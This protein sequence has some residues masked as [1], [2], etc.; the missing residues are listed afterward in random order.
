VL[1]TA[2]LSIREELTPGDKIY[3]IGGAEFVISQPGRSTEDA[4]L[5]KELLLQRMSEALI[6]SAGEGASS[7]RIHYGIVELDP[8]ANLDE[9]PDQPARSIYT[10]TL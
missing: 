5:V 2:I 3:R 8:N 7:L 1:S 9:L 6:G 4:E 10:I